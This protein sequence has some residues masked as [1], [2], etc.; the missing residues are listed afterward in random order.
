MNR[1]V[2]DRLVAIDADAWHMYCVLACLA[3]GDGLVAA[4]VNELSVIVGVSIWTVRKRLNAV[5]AVGLAKVLKD[6]KIAVSQ[7]A[8]GLER[9]LSDVISTPLDSSFLDSITSHAVTADD[10]IRHWSER[11][12]AR[13]GS[14]YNY[15]QFFIAKNAAAKFVKTHGDDSL[16]IV[17][18]VIDHYDAVWRSPQFSRP[19]FGALC[20]WLGE[21]A[22]EYVDKP[23]FTEQTSEAISHK[24]DMKEML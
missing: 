9:I 15:G 14:A 1:L 20:G 24:T 18:V 2:L 10:V 13:Y 17:D 11:Y 22:R 7:A 23:K 5:E 16:A 3:S 19:T 4:N 21:Q 6:G 12:R 8:V